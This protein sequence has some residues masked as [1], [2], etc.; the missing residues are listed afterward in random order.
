MSTPDPIIRFS[1]FAWRIPWTEEH[2]GLRSMGPQR[3]DTMEQ[4]THTPHPSYGETPPTNVTDGTRSLKVEPSGLAT[5]PLEGQ[6]QST[7]HPLGS[8]KTP[9][10]PEP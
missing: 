7:P 9:H 10:P 5:A 6:P 4:L 1:I 8:Q 3:V 2:G